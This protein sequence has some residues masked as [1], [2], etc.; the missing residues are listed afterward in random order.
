MSFLQTVGIASQRGRQIDS[1]NSRQRMADLQE[2]SVRTQQERAALV[3]YLYRQVSQQHYGG[4]QAV[5]P[6]TGMPAQA[7][8]TATVPPAAGAPAAGGALGLKPGGG[9]G[10]PLPPGAQTLPD[11]GGGAAALYTGAAGEE[12]WR[13]ADGGKVPKGMSEMEY[14]NMVI[15]HRQRR[16]EAALRA[17]NEGKPYDQE[18]I[19]MYAPMVP[20]HTPGLVDDRNELNRTKKYANG[21]MVEKPKRKRRRG[22]Y[23]YA[24]G[25]AVMP[26]EMAD[27]MPEM[28]GALDGDVLP[29]A[30]P[31]FD[32]I[33]D[34]TSFNGGL[35][36]IFEE[37]L[38]GI[39]VDLN[40]PE[41]EQ[42]A[43]MVA[44]LYQM[45]MMSPPA[46]A[47]SI[48]SRPPTGDD[49]DMY[50]MRAERVLDS[51]MPAM[52]TF[53]NGGMIQ[54]P[55]QGMASPFPGFADGG[56]VGGALGGGMVRGPGNGT[57]DSVPAMVDGQQP[58]ALSSGEFVVPADVVRALGTNHFQKLIDKYHRRA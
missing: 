20:R 38:Q 52:Q 44:Q 19:D 32:G 37:S 53:A 17:K 36:S 8:A 11:T 5:D 42:H 14:G 24:D 45:S 18:E 15:G 9:Q 4:G 54:P 23:R 16:G 12:P 57:S 3:D 34:D 43:Q 31:K 58:A 47:E 6:V 35:P 22:K 7:P 10:M 51:A 39:G 26:P 28:G 55:G 49:P 40:H 41:W 46:E 29:P 33:Y 25:G 1:E 50:R 21:G 27:A 56:R 13:F 48:E 2:Q 30:P